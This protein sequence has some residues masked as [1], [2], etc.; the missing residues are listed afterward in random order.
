MV[1]EMLRGYIH[2]CFQGC[3]DTYNQTKPS[4]APATCQS[5]PSTHH[6]APLFQ[7][8]ALLEGA[9]ALSFIFFP[10]I[11]TSKLSKGSPNSNNPSSSPTEAPAE[12]YRQ[13]GEKGNG[14]GRCFSSASDELTCCSPL[15][16]GQRRNPASSSALQSTTV[17]S[18]QGKQGGCLQTPRRTTFPQPAG[19]Q[20][21]FAFQTEPPAHFM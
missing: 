14:F 1:L 20:R 2:G 16:K 21:G 15:K 18:C 8:P 10:F 6:Q 4:P 12:H 19:Q 17:F 7:A 11:G 5:H 13:H 9:L 3:S